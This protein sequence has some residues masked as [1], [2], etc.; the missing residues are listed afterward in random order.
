LS[1]Y[2]YSGTYKDTWFGNIE[3]INTTKGLLIS[4]DKMITLQGKLEPFNDHSFVV[5]WNNKNAANDAFIHFKVN[6]ND[7]VTSFDLTPF[8]EEVSNDHEYR[9]MHFVKVEDVN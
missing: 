2:F 4:S 3:I 1:N 9:D 5:R 6:V 7:N 8:Q